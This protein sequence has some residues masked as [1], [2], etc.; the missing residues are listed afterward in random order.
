LAQPPLSGALGFSAHA[1]FLSFFVH[2]F[3]LLMYL[4]CRI[5]RR[6]QVRPFLP[7]VPATFAFFPP[8]CTGP[9]V[10]PTAGAFDPDTLTPLCFIVPA[11]LLFLEHL[12]FSPPGHPLEGTGGC[13][14]PLICTRP[15]SLFCRG[16]F[17]FGQ[18]SP[19]SSSSSLS[20]IF[21]STF[22]WGWCPVFPG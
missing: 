5:P 11:R 9:P 1:S 20:P 17:V 4:R 15:R 13:R 19:V 10:R 18:A 8:L 22:F 16:S 2:P 7:V 21:T 3:P 12:E 14:F 6:F